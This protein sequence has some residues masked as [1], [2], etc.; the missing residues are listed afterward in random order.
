MKKEHFKLELLL[1]NNQNEHNLHYF[2]DGSLLDNTFTD[3]VNK[4]MG[5]FCMHIGQEV[6]KM[7]FFPD[8][9]MVFEE[10]PALLLNA[11]SK[12][13]QNNVITECPYLWIIEQDIELRLHIDVQ[14]TYVNL[15]ILVAPRSKYDLYVF[16]NLEKVVDR[17]VFFQEW[18]K[19][20]RFALSEMLTI[21]PE[22]E[23]DQ[24]YITYKNQ[25]D[26]VDK[27]A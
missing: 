12:G 16:N 22:L 11:I 26:E 24:N 17:G 23:A 15:L 25:L 6:L 18:L 7:D 5:S 14:N 1:H 13:D 19:L 9:S 3:F 20:L 2:T 4:Y 10:V 21:I 27:L 8:F